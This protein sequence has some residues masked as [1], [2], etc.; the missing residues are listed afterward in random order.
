MIAPFSD[1]NCVGGEEISILH[2]LNFHSTLQHDVFPRVNPPRLV[3]L[4]V[5]VELRV[6]RGKAEGVRCERSRKV[7]Y[8]MIT[9][10]VTI[11]T[12]AQQSRRTASRLRRPRRPDLRRSSKCCRRGQE[13][14]A[15][16]GAENSVIQDLVVYR[17]KSVKMVDYDEGGGNEDP[18]TLLT[19]DA[20][21]ERYWYNGVTFE[22]TWADVD[23][24]GAAAV[25]AE[26]GAAL[27]ADADAAARLSLPLPLPLPQA[28]KSPI[29]SPIITGGAA[30]VRGRPAAVFFG[31]PT[32]P[33][34]PPAVASGPRGAPSPAGAPLPSPAG[35]SAAALETLLAMRGALQ[36][37]RLRIAATAAAIRAEVASGAHIRATS[38]L[39][40]GGSPTAT[41]GWHLELSGAEQRV[42]DRG[43]AVLRGDADAAA[44]AAA[45]AERMTD[46]LRTEAD[47][48][49][50]EVTAR[51]ERAAQSALAL[52]ALR[53]E[54][55][56]AAEVAAAFRRD[57]THRQQRAD[58]LIATLEQRIS[59]EADASAARRRS[60]DALDATLARAR[61][62]SEGLGAAK[63]ALEKQVRSLQL[64]LVSS[65]SKA[66]ALRRQLASSSGGGG[67]GASGGGDGGDGLGGGG[68]EGRVSPV[69][70]GRAYVPLVT[71]RSATTGASHAQ[72]RAQHVFAVGESGGAGARSGRT[73]EH[74]LR[75]GRGRGA[76]ALPML[77]TVTSS[78]FLE[79]AAARAAEW[80]R[81]APQRAVGAP[82]PESS[83]DE[84]G[85]AA[86]VPIGAVPRFQSGGR[87]ADVRPAAPAGANSAAAARD[88]RE[89]DGHVRSASPTTRGLGLGG[90][91]GSARGEIAG[92]EAIAFA[93]HHHGA[94]EG[95]EEEDM[96]SSAVVGGGGAADEEDEE[97]PTAAGY[98]GANDN[99]AGAAHGAAA[100]TGAALKSSRPPPACSTSSFDISSSSQQSGLPS[101]SAATSAAR[102]A[103]AALRTSRESS[104]SPFE[105]HQFALPQISP[106]ISP[107]ASPSASYASAGS[108]SC[109]GGVDGRVRARFGASAAAADADA[110]AAAVEAEVEAATLATSSVRRGVPSLATAE[111]QENENE[112]NAAVM[113]SENEVKRREFQAHARDV[114][115][116]A[117]AITESERAQIASTI[118][119]AHDADRRASSSSSMQSSRAGQHTDSG[120]GTSAPQ[121]RPPPRGR[122]PPRSPTRRQTPLTSS[123]SSSFGKEGAPIT[124]TTVRSPRG[125]GKGKGKGGGGH[126]SSSPKSSARAASISVSTSRPRPPS[127]TTA[128]ST[129][130]EAGGAERLQQHSV[131]QQQQRRNGNICSGH[132][133]AQ[134]TVLKQW[135]RKHFVLRED[136]SMHGTVGEGEDEEVNTHI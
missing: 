89:F 65:R 82:S 109:E 51:D 45:A 44:A 118:A 37:Q 13:R 83:F 135:R 39:A 35:A 90:G 88:G 40:S 25:T 53:S 105:Q 98:R 119:N 59:R 8:S 58:D 100:T 117:A 121:A 34:P 123:S 33:L 86:A 120:S 18:W 78:P 91:G 42:A 61:A 96:V 20:T 114:A 50:R 47:A 41:A 129:V 106:G 85:S 4:S 125:G 32:R 128:S 48:L 31:D 108:A 38:P 79:E 6:Q 87:R 17:K 55:A 9:T 104:A 124:F 43:A 103:S 36:A 29:P 131:A 14:A 99:S 107:A 134:G 52:D 66:D 63:R 57:A 71:P 94:E 112:S 126:S 133:D 72:G 64:E 111:S 1:D 11:R 75:G 76:D 3:R 2:C 122:P 93:D 15:W 84:L 49:R 56:A 130:A 116:A 95:E 10:S 113:M 60:R 24:V 73:R 127:A 23:E 22:S 68:S 30:L 12:I 26:G 77:P 101:T 28:R 115:A 110:A 27:L 19:D 62:E 67:G 132:L 74:D 81:S 92:P 46:A 7:S 69:E 97:E 21:G 70:D 16:A 102:S 5:V 136:G 80:L 54:G